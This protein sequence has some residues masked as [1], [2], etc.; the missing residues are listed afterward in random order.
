[1]AY[2]R[3]AVRNRDAGRLL[4]AVLK[5]V[6]SEVREPGYVVAGCVDSDDATRFMERIAARE[7]GLF[8]V[9]AGHAISFSA[10]GANP[11]RA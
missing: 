1:M 11:Q 7:R 10:R 8:I 6:E 2:D 3:S 4:T 9:R 5:R